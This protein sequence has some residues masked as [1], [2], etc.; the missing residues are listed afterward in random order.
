MAKIIATTFGLALLFFGLGAFASPNVLGTHS[1]PLGNLLHLVVGAMAAAAA[2]RGGAST[3][4][5]CCAGAGAFLLLWGLAGYGFG[6]PGESTLRAMPPDM[7]L[8]VVIPGFLESGRADHLLH[9]FLGIAFGVAAV[10][11]VAETP[12]RLRK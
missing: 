11:G 5:W 4:F 2:Q 12:F 9:L 8:L 6:Q 3:L 10:A 7:K 1:S